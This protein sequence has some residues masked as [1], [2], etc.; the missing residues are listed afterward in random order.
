MCLALS[1]AVALLQEH[2]WS[3]K[4]DDKDEKVSAA[5]RD[6]FERALG[7]FKKHL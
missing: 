2:G 4:G 1:G 7:W 5:A 3:L 6:A